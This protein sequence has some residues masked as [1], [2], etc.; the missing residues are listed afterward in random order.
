MVLVDR[1]RFIEHINQADKFNTARFS[2]NTR[3]DFV[4][5]G[6]G[7]FLPEHTTPYALIVI[8]QD[9]TYPE[10]TRTSYYIGRG[11]LPI[12]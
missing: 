6:F 2:D 10:F 7:Y 12:N 9:R 11:S 1:A 4:Y 8:A 3:K 5:T